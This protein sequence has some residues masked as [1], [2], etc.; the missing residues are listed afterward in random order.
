MLAEEGA[1]PRQIAK[2]CGDRLI[3]KMR[4]LYVNHCEL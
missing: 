1:V 3:H 2:A 4:A